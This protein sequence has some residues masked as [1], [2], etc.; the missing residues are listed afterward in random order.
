MIE[1]PFIGLYKDV[2]MIGAGFEEP[3]PLPGIEH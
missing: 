1:I 3:T 2:G